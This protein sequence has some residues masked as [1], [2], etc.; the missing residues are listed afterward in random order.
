MHDETLCLK[1]GDPPE[2]FDSLVTPVHRASTIV[3]PTVAAYQARHETIYDGYSYGLYGTPTSRAL[4]LQLAGL[5]RAAKSLVVQSGFAAIVVTTLA[6]A[7]SGQQ[8]LFPDCAYDTVRPF[9][10]NFLGGLGVE[11]VFYDP[12]LG[13]GIESLLTD[14]T[15]LVW[16]ESP[17]SMTMEVQDIPAIAAAARRRGIKVA[18]DNT[19][20]TPLRF[21]PLDHGVDF[22][23][24]AISKYI[25]GHSDLIMGAVSVADEA[26]Y[27]RLKDFCRYLGYGVSADECSLALRGLETLAVR[28]DR[29]EA[30]ALTLARWL[31]SQPFVAEVRHPALASNPGHDIW[32]RDF[33]GATGVFSVLVHPW[34][35]NGLAEAIEG[36]EH[37]AIGASWG[38][39]HSVVAVLDAPPPRTARPFEHDGP[40]LRFSIGL[41]HVDDLKADIEGSFSRLSA[42]ARPSTEILS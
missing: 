40:L 14:R 20:A 42:D 34:A 4:E 35:R 24:T 39:V 28:L 1:R 5:E 12:L 25:N 30:S 29:C 3:F 32:R 7:R 8:V 13:E 6:C 21:K 41:E 23:M 15:A 19:W 33:S 26:L 10:A 17:G 11:A 37:F 27:R 31:Q 2:T 16:V 18:A 38:G 22:S 9:A 36:L